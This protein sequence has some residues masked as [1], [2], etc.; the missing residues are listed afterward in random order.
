MSISNKWLLPLAAA[1]LFTAASV[2][3]AYGAGSAGNTSV[4]VGGTQNTGFF[5]FYYLF[6]VV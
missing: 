2:A 6:F 5:S 1:L 3:N 4:H